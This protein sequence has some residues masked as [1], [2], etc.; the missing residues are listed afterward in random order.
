[1]HNTFWTE[2]EC[3][4]TTLESEYVK[5]QTEKNSINTELNTNSLI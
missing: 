3:T 4:D 2:E 5:K 1:M